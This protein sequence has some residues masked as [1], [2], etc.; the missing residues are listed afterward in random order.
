M[1]IDVYQEFVSQVAGLRNL[2]IDYVVINAGVLRYPNV[3]RAHHVCYL[4]Q[5][6]STDT[7]REQPSCTYS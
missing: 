4:V 1:C 6:A 3:S 7:S 5:G 2:K